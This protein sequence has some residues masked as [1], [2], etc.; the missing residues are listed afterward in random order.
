MRCKS[1]TP[2]D[3]Q[4]QRRSRKIQGLGQACWT[5]SAISTPHTSAPM[6]AALPRA[7]D[8]NPTATTDTALNR[9]PLMSSRSSPTARSGHRKRRRYRRDAAGKLDDLGPASGPEDNLASYGG[10][11]GFAANDGTPALLVLNP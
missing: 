5:E 7:T 11:P 10:A 2:M 6:R 1:T 3:G 8:A 9:V 4:K